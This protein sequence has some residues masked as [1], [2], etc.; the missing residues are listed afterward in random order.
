M[1]DT[2][3]PYEYI[4]MHISGNA[5]LF[6][7]TFYLTSGLGVMS[8]YHAEYIYSIYPVYFQ[9]GLLKNDPYTLQTTFTVNEENTRVFY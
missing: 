7:L 1:T 2:I 4:Q 6:L 9:W 8:F 3:K 5:V